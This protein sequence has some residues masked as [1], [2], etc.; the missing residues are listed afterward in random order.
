MIVVLQRKLNQQRM[1]V[2]ERQFFSQSLTHLTTLSGRNVQVE[3]WMVT[4]YEVDFFEEIG[5][6]GLYVDFHSFGIF[7]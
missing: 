1:L 5:S 3:D 7:L 2:Q 4:A 6:G